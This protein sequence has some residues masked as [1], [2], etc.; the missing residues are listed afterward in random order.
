METR[1]NLWEEKLS[2]FH[3]RFFSSFFLRL[4]QQMKAQSFPICCKTKKNNKT[5]LEHR[6]RRRTKI[7]LATNGKRNVFTAIKDRHF[8]KPLQQLAH[9]KLWTV[10]ENFFFVFTTKR[11]DETLSFR[12]NFTIVC[13]CG[14][15]MKRV[16]VRNF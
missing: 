4:L 5:G 15:Y 3:F 2:Y 7:A 6:D 11:I 16:S 8:P 10:E 13:G 9:V 12:W 1:K 14:V